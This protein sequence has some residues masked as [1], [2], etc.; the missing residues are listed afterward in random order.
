MLSSSIWNKIFKSGLSKF[1]GRHPLRNLKGQPLRNLLSPPLNTLSHL[2]SKCKIHSDNFSESAFVGIV[3][4]CWNLENLKVF[5]RRHM[6]GPIN[7]LFI[8]SLRGA[9]IRLSAFFLAPANL[10]YFANVHNI[11]QLTEQKRYIFAEIYTNF[12]QCTFLHVPYRNLERIR[13]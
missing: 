13:Y 8:K 5:P 12:L 1:C 4:K 6:K 2:F 9:A 3:L 10:I 7:Q 11:V